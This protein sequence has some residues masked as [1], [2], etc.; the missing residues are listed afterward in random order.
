MSW[1]AI[2]KTTNAKLDKAKDFRY[3]ALLA[4]FLLFLDFSL[5]IFLDHSLTQVTYNLAK[6]RFRIGQM[7]I[8]LALFAFFL[9]FVVPFIQH[10]IRVAALLVPFSWLNYFHYDEWRGVSP[11]NYVR[12]SELGKLAVKNN[13]SVLYSYYKELVAEQDREKQL[14][15]ICLA[16]LVTALF[17]VYAYFDNANALVS[18]LFIFFDENK[19]SF[20]A[21]LVALPLYALCLFCFYFGV[22]RGGGFSLRETDRI[23]FR[24][25]GFKD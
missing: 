11:N 22:I 1:D 18:A 7:L 10:I 16:F 19:D 8:F 23:H 9:S 17:D 20:W 6:E 14:N 4:S 3:F 5:V 12:V 13:N 25:H 24:D 21:G 15:Y 2:V